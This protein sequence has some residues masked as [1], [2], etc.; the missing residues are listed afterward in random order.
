MVK[1]SLLGVLSFS[2]RERALPP[3]T[4]ISVLTVVEKKKYGEAFQGVYFWRMGENVVL[5]F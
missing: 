2:D 5:R 3:S 1:T 4:E